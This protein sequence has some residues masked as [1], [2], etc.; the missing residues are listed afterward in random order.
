[1]QGKI[2]FLF[3]GMKF[4]LICIQ[5]MNT[6]LYTSDSKCHWLPILNAAIFPENVSTD[7]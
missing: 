6:N 1:M 3:E 4:Q 2:F 7:Q 5:N